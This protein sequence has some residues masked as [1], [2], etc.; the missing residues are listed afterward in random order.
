MIRK[1]ALP[2]LIRRINTSNVVSHK[3]NPT[4]P[5]WLI[6]VRQAAAMLRG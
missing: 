1:D 5:V 3:L 2:G 4:V 6:P